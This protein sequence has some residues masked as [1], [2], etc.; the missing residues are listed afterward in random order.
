M[1]ARVIENQMYVAM[2]GT[3]GNLLFVPYMATDYGRA[4]I[5]IILPR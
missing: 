4:A 5:A 3:G 2:T 1:S